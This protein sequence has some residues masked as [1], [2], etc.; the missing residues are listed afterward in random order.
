M[1]NFARTTTNTVRPLILAASKP[2]NPLVGPALMRQ[3]GR[4]ASGNPRQA[5]RRAL[6]LQITQLDS[7]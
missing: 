7:P 6:K 3:A 4:H 5:A 2:R 1:S